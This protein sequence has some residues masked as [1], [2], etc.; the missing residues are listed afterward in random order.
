MSLKYPIGVH[1]YHLARLVA[2]AL[3]PNDEWVKHD[4]TIGL[5]HLGRHTP[6]AYLHP[7]D[8]PKLA[9]HIRTLHSIHVEPIKKFGKA[10]YAARVESTGTYMWHPHADVAILKAFVDFQRGPGPFRFSAEEDAYY[11]LL[12]KNRANL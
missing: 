6:I 11:D 12:L 1:D 7:E 2:L 10:G 4:Y 8:T 9:D 5:D 3:G